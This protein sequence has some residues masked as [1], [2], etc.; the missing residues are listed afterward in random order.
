MCP[1]ILWVNLSRFDT[2]PDK[3]TWLEVSDALIRRGYETVILAGYDK[4]KYQPETHSVRLKYFGAVNRGGLFRCTL[5]ANMC[6]WIVARAR[7]TD[8]IIIPPGALYIAPFLNLSGKKNIHLDIRTVPVDVH[9]LRDR[10]NKYL[11]WTFPMRALRRCVRGYSFITDHLRTSVEQEFAVRFV[12]YAL[13]QS[14]VNSGRFVQ[15][16]LPKS[17]SANG[18][19]VL[20]YHGTITKNRGVGL[21]I[22]A[23]SKL[24]NGL[25]QKVRFIVVGAGPDEN[26]MRQLAVKLGLGDRVVFKGLIDYERIPEEIAMADCGICP[27]P[28][29]HEWNVSSPIKVFEYMASAKPVILTPIPAHKDVIGGQDFVVWTEGFEA[30]DF[31]KAIEYAYE[32]RGRLARKAQAAPALVKERHEWDIQGGKLASYITSRFELM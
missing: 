20:F 18:E 29:R 4:V 26:A 17:G 25:R 10:I 30:V 3:S 2:K 15:R 1:R 8:V 27:L 16:T 6:L 21:I 11:F 13:W 23:L 5:L 19:F 31:R 24:T 7:R 32:N 12:D 22:M 9:T 28:N 14:G